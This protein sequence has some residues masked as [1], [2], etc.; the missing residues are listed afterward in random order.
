MIYHSVVT[1]LKTIQF[2]RTMVGPCFLTQAGWMNMLGH[3]SSDMERIHHT[4][5][6]DELSTAFI[7][8]I[9]GFQ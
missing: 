7:G 3:N 9:A 5:M 2:S 6:K 1:I 4:W 8:W